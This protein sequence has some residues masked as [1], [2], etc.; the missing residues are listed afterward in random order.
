MTTRLWSPLKQKQD[1][2]KMLQSILCC[3]SFEFL[4]HVL[5]AKHSS[6][7]RFIT[8]F[9]YPRTFNSI[10]GGNDMGWSSIN[11]TTIA[12]GWRRRVNMFIFSP[13]SRQSDDDN[14]VSNVYEEMIKGCLFDISKDFKGSR[15]L[16]AWVK[17]DK[18]PITWREKMDKSV[19]RRNK[20]NYIKNGSFCLFE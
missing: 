18:L 6:Q 11:W 9:S 3:Y 4:P 5:L 13:E 7:I 2:H 12:F 8:E 14:L 17:G 16:I 20:F 19:Y 1:P 15:Q 10:A